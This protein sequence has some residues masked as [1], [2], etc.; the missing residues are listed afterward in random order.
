MFFFP[1]S[2]CN[3][4]FVA[5]ASVLI[6][7]SNCIHHH[8]HHHRLTI[9]LHKINWIEDKSSEWIQIRMITK[10]SPLNKIE[11]GFEK[12][13]KSIQD[14]RH[15]LFPNWMFQCFSVFFFSRK[16][17]HTKMP[18]NYSLI[19]Y[20]LIYSLVEIMNEFCL[21]PLWSN[22]KHFKFSISMWWRNSNN[23]CAV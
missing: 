22:R 8:H 16:S 23:I 14:K 7:S 19:P 13:E 3:F 10:K 4:Y 2:I 18:C 5:F 12:E 11:S 17:D 21:L 20:N 15:L 9:I 1:Q 6:S